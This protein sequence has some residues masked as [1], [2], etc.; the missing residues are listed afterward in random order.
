MCNVVDQVLKRFPNLD[1]LSLVVEDRRACAPGEV[2]LIDLPSDRR[3]TGIVTDLRR[4][5]DNLYLSRQRQLLPHHVKLP[6]FRLVCAIRGG[7]RSS[8][9]KYESEYDSDEVSR[10]ENEPE[11]EEDLESSEDGVESL[12]E[13]KYGR[14]S[15]EGY[16]S[17]YL[18][19][20]SL[21]HGRRYQEAYSAYKE[22]VPS[23]YQ[24]GWLTYLEDLL[25]ELQKR[26]SS[27]LE[28]FPPLYR[29]QAQE[30]NN[31]ERMLTPPVASRCCSGD[32]KSNDEVNELCSEK[33]QHR[34]FC[35]C[36]GSA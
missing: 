13:Y 29:P 14:M 24:Q 26:D 27:Y 19:D 33:K 30:G 28:N 34:W 17:S 31:S 2:Q 16:S 18:E 9:G 12:L 23:K 22:D 15:D 11:S 6:K 8:I 35:V 5:I 3:D 32:H 4:I 21:D 1:E 20:I 7:E 36:F 25:A 10:D